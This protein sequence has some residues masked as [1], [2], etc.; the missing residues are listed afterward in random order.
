MEKR[1]S[2]PSDVS[3]DEWPSSRRF[4]PK[5]AS[6]RGYRGDYD[7]AKRKEG[8]KVNMAADTLELLLALIVTPANEQERDQVDSLRE[9]V[10][11]APGETARLAHV[12]QGYTGAEPAEAAAGYGIRPKVVKHSETKRGFVFLPRRWVVERSCAWVR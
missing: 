3:D 2:Y 10:Q 4:R 11:E 12:G 8:T 7:G 5:S 6:E 9:A 1:T